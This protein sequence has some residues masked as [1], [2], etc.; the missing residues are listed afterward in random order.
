LVK[1]SDVILLSSA[2]YGEALRRII[3]HLRIQGTLT[4]AEARDMLGT[5]RKY[6][7]AILEHADQ[8]HITARRGDDRVLGPKA[9]SNE[10]PAGLS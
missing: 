7:L 8:Q 5:S 9:P 6:M 4:V 2:A 1:V 10:E 3:A